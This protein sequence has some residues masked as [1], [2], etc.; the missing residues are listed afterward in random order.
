MPGSKTI[1]NVSPGFV[2]NDDR[3]S[4][5]IIQYKEGQ[6]M[7]VKKR[8]GLLFLLGSILSVML[9]VQGFA[10]QQ[11][12]P[13]IAAGENKLGLETTTKEDWVVILKLTDTSY[14]GLVNATEGSLEPIE[15]KGA[16]LS[17]ETAELEAWYEKL[18]DVDGI[19]M[20]HGI[21][22]SE[23]GWIEEFRMTD[24]GGYIIEFFRWRSHRPEAT[25]YS[26]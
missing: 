9:F 4:G 14:L 5:T 20:I 15:N 18:K 2:D 1:L 26:R 16:M 22:E 25:K 6:E 10:S 12:N 17:I 19:N 21:E 24:P 23:D 8:S 3:C 7:S 13:S 11:S